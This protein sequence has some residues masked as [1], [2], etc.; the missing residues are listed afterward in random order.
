ML[1]LIAEALRDAG[2]ARFT[3]ALGDLGLFNALLDALP[4]PRR[5]RRRLRHQFWRPDAFR[6]ELARLTSQEA[7]QAHGLPRDL[8]DTLDPAPT[9]AAPQTSS[10]TTSTRSGI[11]LIGTRT[12]AEIAERLLAEAADARET[13][14]AA[15]D[16]R[17]DR[18]L[19]GA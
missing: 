17:A 18:E 3:A 9:P 2:L 8:I 6:A 15:E 4:M 19:R 1:A 14:L 13:P 12:L 7:L 16:G 10:T 11:E 5:W